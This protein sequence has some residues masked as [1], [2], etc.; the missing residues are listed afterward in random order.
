M[1]SLIGRWAWGADPDAFDIQWYEENIFYPQYIQSEEEFPIPLC[2]IS[3]RHDDVCQKLLVKYGG[4]GKEFR[5]RIMKGCYLAAIGNVQ[6]VGLNGS[7]IVASVRSRTRLG[8]YYTIEKI[9]G[10][11]HCSCPDFKL[12]DLPIVYANQKLCK[13]LI[14]Y[15][16]FCHFKE[17]DNVS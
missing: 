6:L 7:S 1:S 8:R 5:R 16:V 4:L 13:H 17:V 9:N 12:N 11:L 15:K 14:A 10:Q 3:L 2:R